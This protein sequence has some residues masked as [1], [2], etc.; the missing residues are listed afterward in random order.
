MDQRK[1]ASCC[2]WVDGTLEICPNCKTE[3]Y[4]KEKEQYKIDK[5]KAFSSVEIPLIEIYD[6]DS[7]IVR[8]FKKIIRFHQMVFFFIVTVIGYIAA[9]VVG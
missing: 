9:S 6:T 1:C 7:I 2:E 4:A 5:K 8:F 3:F